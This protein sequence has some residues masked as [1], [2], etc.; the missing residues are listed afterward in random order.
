PPY[1]AILTIGRTLG[2]LSARNGPTLYRRVAGLLEPPKASSGVGR[3]Y[4]T[5]S[6]L[7]D[8]R[9]SPTPR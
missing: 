1:K 3:P 6:S 4:L 9:R 8:S 7:T 5:P 2:M